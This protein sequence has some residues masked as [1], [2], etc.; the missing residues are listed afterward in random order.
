MFMEGDLISAESP[1]MYVLIT[2]ILIAAHRAYF[3][4]NP[5]NQ[6]TDVW[7][8]PNPGRQPV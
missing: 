2:A 8:P 3:Y 6:L 1:F 5:H 7:Q 4:L